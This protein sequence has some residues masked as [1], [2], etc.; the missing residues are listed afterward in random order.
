VLQHNPVVRRLLLFGVPLAVAVLGLIHPGGVTNPGHD[1][2]TIYEQLRDQADLF[3][4]VHLLQLV[5]FG[6]LVLVV[7]ILIDGLRGPA[8]TVSRVALL[9]FGIVYT[10]FDSVQG[11]AMGVMVQQ[12]HDLAEAEQGAVH[13]LIEAY[14]DSLITGYFNVLGGVGSLAWLV[15]LM[16]AAVA[17][18]RAGAGTL[19]VVC[20]VLA[21]V[22]FGIGHPAPFGPIGMVFLLIAVWRLEGERRVRAARPVSDGPVGSGVTGGG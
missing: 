1:G 8:A 3:I 5:V 9:V 18:R 7:W 14:Q 13:N 21:G 10:A 17:L 4:A 15:A 19:A 2:D 12:G 22:V 11:I 6:L 16:A 20:M